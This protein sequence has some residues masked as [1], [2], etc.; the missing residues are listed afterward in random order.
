ME[1]KWYKWK[2]ILTTDEYY[3]LKKHILDLQIIIWHKNNLINLLKSHL[4]NLN[5]WNENLKKENIDFRNGFKLIIVILLI[6][7]FII[8]FDNIK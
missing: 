2:I 4:I 6:G 8:Y 5:V 3:K 7:L 1:K